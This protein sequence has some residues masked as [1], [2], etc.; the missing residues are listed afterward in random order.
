M[1]Q[2]GGEHRRDG[3]RGE[4]PEHQRSRAE[5]ASMEGCIAIRAATPISPAHHRSISN[6]PLGEL[7]LRIPG[8][9]PDV[10]AANL[11]TAIRL[12]VQGLT[13]PHWF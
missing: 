13:E 2:G 11:R 10:P 3:V 5:A 6:L 7:R 8:G 4:D 1:N 9:R 12:V